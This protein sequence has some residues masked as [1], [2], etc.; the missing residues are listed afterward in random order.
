MKVAARTKN[1]PLQSENTPFGGCATPSSRPTLQPHKAARGYVALEHSE[2][3]GF[4]GKK[5]L[6]K[7][8]FGR[9]SSPLARGRSRDPHLRRRHKGIGE[10]ENGLEAIALA[11][12][13]ES[14]VVL[15]DVE[16]PVMGAEGAVEQILHAA[17][18][19][20]ILVLTMH[21]NPHLIRKLLTLG[22]HAHLGRTR[23]GINS[24]VWYAPYIGAGIVLCCRY[25]VT[26]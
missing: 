4:E 12:R 10:A 7:G 14:N 18:L 13:E 20:N 9:R 1:Y 11:E 6:Y 21:D 3:V 22:A 16:M 19:T 26:R 17:P 15:L 8:A 5:R 2:G 23:P 24:L 25:R